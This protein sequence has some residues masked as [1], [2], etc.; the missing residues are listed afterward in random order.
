MGSVL[1][2]GGAGFIGFHVGQQT[3]RDVKADEAGRPSDENRP[4]P[5]FP[6]AQP[7]PAANEVQSSA[8]APT[9]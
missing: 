4:H 9:I 5:G 1:V 2:T 6:S 3:A 8:T 7:D